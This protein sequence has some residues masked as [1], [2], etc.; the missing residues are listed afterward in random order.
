M[1]AF[2][3]KNRNILPIFMLAFFIFLSPLYSASARENVNDWYI[4][5]FKTR[6]EVLSDDSAIITEDIIADSGKAIKHGIFRILPIETKTPDGTIYTPIELISI[7]D[8]NNQ[9]Y[10]YN[11]SKEYKT[12]TWKIGDAKINVSGENNYRIKYRVDNIIR[13]QAGA[14][15]LYWNLSGNYWD[16]EIDSF[17]A[18]IILPP[19][20]N[21]DN[22][23]IFLYSGSF[24]DKNN[25]L[26]SYAWSTANALEIIA[27]KSLSKREGLSISLSFPKGYIKH[28][29][30]TKE[31]TTPLSQL[32]T[33]QLA[34]N[35]WLAIILA[36]LYILLVPV[37]VFII[38][39]I[40]YRRRQKINIYQH[41]LIVTEY[42]PPDNI[43]PIILGYLSGQKNTSSLITASIV[44]MA[45]L[46]L[47]VI[48]EEAKKVLFIK[49]E[50]L[51][52]TKTDTQDNYQQLDETEKYI[53][54]LIFKDNNTVNSNSLKEV[55]LRQQLVINNKIKQ[56]AKDRGYLLKKNDKLKRN[57]LIAAIIFFLILS[58][59][60]AIILI[61]FYGKVSNLS[62]KGEKL[63]WQIKGFKQYLT[64]AEKGR[65]SFYE[66]ENIFT[67][68]LPYSIAIG[69]V[70]EWAKKMQDIYGEEYIND[71]LNWYLGASTLSS[72]SKLDSI[73][74]NINSI[75]HNISSSTGS[76]S[77]MGGGG[78][79]GG[80][81][82]GGGG[83]GW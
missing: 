49:S 71:S 76:S 19:E 79:S 39:Y 46:K 4:K 31:S 9:P 1:I 67:K 43:S 14:D 77:G 81:S 57:Y 70:K 73:T 26:A 80:G 51:E 33:K 55:F 27:N 66:K 22:S 82:G 54:D 15:E 2:T 40:Y 13:D 21:S 41:R 64:V 5:E 60:P 61:I 42:S 47:L 45:V 6:I 75:S 25:E 74:N 7:T 69:S 72:I 63:H 18:E 8:F 50:Y 17:K 56:V 35:S 3:K 78:F 12:I 29:I 30:I 34:S 36:L 59:L 62:E 53:Y 68:F 38:A 28:Q 20:I 32:A 23:E 10:K 48:K 44:R 11:T 24:G 58:F 65:H 37:L 83:G 16:L 52:F